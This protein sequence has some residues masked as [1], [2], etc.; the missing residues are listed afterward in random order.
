MAKTTYLRKGYIRKGYI[1]KGGIKVKRARVPAVRVKFPKL[2]AEERRKRA[3]RALRILLPAAIK[4]VGQVGFREAA[5]RLANK[6]GIKDPERLAGWLK[7]QALRRGVLSP[8]HKYRGRLGYRKAPAMAK[9]LGPK[10][11]KAYLRALR[12]RKA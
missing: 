1:R 8:A 9:K 10:K 2:T 11:Y 6:A 5:K 7:G 12:L 3:D 4:W